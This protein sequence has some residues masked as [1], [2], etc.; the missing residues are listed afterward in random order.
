MSYILLFGENYYPAGWDDFKGEFGTLDDALRCASDLYGDEHIED[1]YW[2]EVI[3]TG[4]WKVVHSSA[5]DWDFLHEARY[6]EKVHLAYPAA[7]CVRDGLTFKPME[8]DTEDANI[9][10]S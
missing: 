3:D 8:I 2:H 1:Y 4:T 10:L 7:P 9:R 6:T 5:G